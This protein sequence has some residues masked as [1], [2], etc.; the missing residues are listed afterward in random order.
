MKQYLQNI[1]KPN[2]DVSMQK[3]V[4]VSAAI[5]VC[6]LLL[7]VFQKWLDSLA[8]NEMPVLFQKLD[9]GNYF[10]RFAIWILLGTAISV[11]AKTPLRASVNTFLF[12]ISMVS[13]YYLYCSFV[14]GF[15]P[16]TYMLLWLA[17][18]F[19]SPLLACICWYAKGSGMVAVLISSGI[20]GVLFAQAFFITQGFRVAH[21]PEVI[22]WAAGLILLRRKPKECALML[23]LSLAV[24]LVCQGLF[25]YWG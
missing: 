4:L 10:G 11:Y 14:L 18:S 2:A 12:F 7:G 16:K 22:T 1:R 25:P 24:A 20:L 21:I 13:G 8:F 15:L 23:G 3:K 5:F 9:L 19:V 6:G 17:A